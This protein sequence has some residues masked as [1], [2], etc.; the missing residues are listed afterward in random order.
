MVY[1]CAYKQ[2]TMNESDARQ[3]MLSTIIETTSGSE[4]VQSNKIVRKRKRMKRCTLEKDTERMMKQ[5]EI[6][7]KLVKIRKSQVAAQ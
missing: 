1:T 5:R 7:I 4:S 3:K 6:K 2:S